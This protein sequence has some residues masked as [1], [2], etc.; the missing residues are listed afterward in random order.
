VS[1]TLE[2]VVKT[3]V[4]SLGYDLVELRRHGS[5]GRPVLDVRID[6]RDG[7]AVSVDDCTR[8]SRALEARLDAAL[9]LAGDRYV[10]EVSSPGVERP[11]RTA[12]DWRRFAGQEASVVADAVGGR[13]T[14]T[15]ERVEGATGAEA[16]ILRDAR[17][18]EHHVPLAAIREARLVFHW[19]R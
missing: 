6:R 19:K 12:T 18:G 1:Q 17:G 14:V 16:V 4:D 11:L 8:V 13:A 3:E 5:R 2:D 10:L 7:S 15:I 9:E